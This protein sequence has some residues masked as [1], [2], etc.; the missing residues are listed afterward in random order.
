[1]TDNDQH[2]LTAAAARL[3]AT[4]GGVELDATNRMLRDVANGTLIKPKL[5][6]ALVN[7]SLALVASIEPRDGTEAMLAVQM[8]N[9]HGPI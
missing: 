4:F 1:M 7:E 9:T 6:D 5:S 2:A 8:A 3:T